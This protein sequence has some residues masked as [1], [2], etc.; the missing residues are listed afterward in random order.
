MTPDEI[1]VLARYV[2]ALCPAQKFDEY[3]PDAWADLFGG[4]PYSLA[5]CRQGAARAAAKKP[6]VSPAEIIAE[7]KQLREE[8]LETFQYE[9]VPGD[10]DTTVYLAAYRQQRAA[11]A[12]GTRPPVLALTGTRR[13][14]LEAA[15]KTLGGSLADGQQPDHPFADR[16]GPL[17]VE[18][19]KCRA[20]I[21]RPCRTPAP[22]RRERPTHPARK[23]A[24]THQQRHT[25]A[26]DTARAAL[27]ALTPEQRAQLL[28][29]LADA[30]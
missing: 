21:G 19:P 10:D 7:V 12:D 6:F 26:Q 1:V 29:E 4:T 20:A 18:C 9:P 24:A 14:E 15:V 3:T 5:D 13:P 2:R 28:A 22:F 11:C 8:R 16:R 30:S 27:A 23:T 25:G 17:G